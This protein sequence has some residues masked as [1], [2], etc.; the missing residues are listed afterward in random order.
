M[1]E[2]Q[3][4]AHRSEDRKKG[5]FYKGFFIWCPSGLDPL[6][7]ASA[8]LRLN[9]G[10]E[11]DSRRVLFKAQRLQHSATPS[12]LTVQP[13]IK[14]QP[15]DFGFAPTHRS[16][17]GFTL[18]ISG[19]SDEDSINSRLKFGKLHS[20]PLSS[21]SAEAAC[22]T[23]QAQAVFPLSIGITPSTR[24]TTRGSSTAAFNK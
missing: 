6:Q 8:P 21:L 14:R 17:I 1:F 3:S 23:S 11:L 22:S 9:T 2:L 4:K 5:K 15:S 20:K 12:G 16:E 7:T 13:R 18:G 10:C 19:L 24:R